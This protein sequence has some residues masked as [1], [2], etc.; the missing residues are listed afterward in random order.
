MN[1]L[2]VSL[3]APA[4]GVKKKMY[5]KAYYLRRAGIETT[6]LILI[7]G[8][9]AK[10]AGNKSDLLAVNFWWSGILS[11]L[12]FFW[13]LS[14]MVEQWQMYHALQKYLHSANDFDFILMR[15]PVADYFLNRFMNRFSRD[16]KI[17]F[18]H[19]TLERPELKLR[20]ANSF[21]YQYFL[22][23]ELRFGT[24]VRMSAAGM[25]AVSHEIARHQ[26]R[27]VD[28]KVPVATIS[29]GID[30]SRLKRK[31]QSTGYRG[32]V[33]NLLFLAGSDSPWHGLDILLNSLQA[34]GGPVR[35]HCYIAGNIRKELLEKSRS[36]SMV[37]VL[38]HQSNEDLDALIEQCHVGIGSLALFRNHME[39]ACTLKVREY[40]GRGLP[41]VVGYND[42]DLMGN[43][44]MLDYFLRV[45][46]DRT[47][48]APTFD[49]EDIVRFAQRVYAKEDMHQIIQTAV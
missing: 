10:V 36:L 12:A 1:L 24:N 23:G 20:A 43:T 37:T 5:D 29:N 38:P 8:K 41:F 11:R 49:V 22:K 18:E 6:I 46:V 9:I 34:Y 7:D 39:E 15:Y 2:Y 31:S 27:I 35:L 40:W 44:A 33:L 47:L 42:T 13:R 26:S 21:W 3:G 25:V 32:G 4:E 16:Y 28:E 14:V 17:V 30:V 19:N 48:S 45:H